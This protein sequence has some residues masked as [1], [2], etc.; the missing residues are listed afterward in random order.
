M[1]KK[2]AL[3]SIF[4]SLTGLLIYA[5]ISCQSS[6]VSVSRSGAGISEKVKVNIK[7]ISPINGGIFEGWGTSLCWWGNRLG[8]DE[9]ISSEAVD[10]FFSMD[11]GIGL[12]II[13]Y[14][15]GGGDDPEH[16]HI[17]RS[18]SVMPG[19]WKNVDEFGNFEYDWSADY[20]QRNVLKK[21]AAT[22]DKNDLIV[23]F[24]SNSPPYFMTRSGCSSGSKTGLAT[25]I[26]NDMYDDFADYMAE[27]TYK[28][29]EIDGIKV[30]SLEPMNEP[31]S[32]SWSAYN[33]KQEG[34]RIDVGEEQSKLLIE[35]RKALDKRGLKD[36]IV[37]G[38]DETGTG[39][40]VSSF[41][42]LSPE[43]KQVLNRINTHTYFGDADRRLLAVASGS[44]KDLWVSETDGYT[45]VGKDNG[46]M[47]S[48]LAFA[49]KILK[50]MNG[51][52]PSAWLIWQSVAS[53]VSDKPFNGRIDGLPDCTNGFW[54]TAFADFINDRI[55]LTK[56][57][58]AFG[59]F[60]KYI[61]PGSY[62]I[63]TGLDN[64]IASYNP[65]TKEIAVVCV[66]PNNIEKTCAFD[67]SSFVKSWSEVKAV[68]TS[69]K[70]L[71]EG[72]NMEVVGMPV[73]SLEEGVFSA[74][75]APSS[76]T[77][78]VIGGVKLIEKDRE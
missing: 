15:I 27:V 22:V 56:K 60:T 37:S 14:N 19:F 59:Q 10:L 69:G 28:L 26:K 23:E 42:A 51:M 61:R 12:N 46:Q 77:T 55:I 64:Y 36:V 35:T 33:P 20:R 50:D 7:N 78:F 63:Y 8:G 39:Y 48:A 5:L 52:K 71:E 11:N 38:T 13:R 73:T 1:K 49:Q 44:K 17:T 9:K 45:S 25:N 40:Q 68:R 21:I 6:N 75:L 30:A 65:A 62:V 4:I 66:N 24:F 41:E 43:A 2:Y 53:Y 67:L 74:S 3:K 72:E 57:Y 70:T 47:G 18:D 29:Q 58:Y 54:G 76:I 32:V 34:C 16:N 31:R